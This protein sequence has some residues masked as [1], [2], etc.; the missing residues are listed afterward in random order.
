MTRLAIGIDIGGTGIKGGLVN[1]KSGALVGERI[2]V[3]TPEGGEPEDIA[4]VTREIIE[5]LNAPADTPIGVAFPSAIRGGITMLA[6]NVSKRWIGFEAEKFFE[7]ELGREIHFI[8]DA[9][10]A[11]F[12]EVKYGAARDHEGLVILTTLGTGIGSAFIYNG[13]LI[14]N[15]ELGHLEIDGF[16]AETKASAVARERDGIDYVEWAGRLQ[17]YYSHVEMLFSPDLFLVGGGVSKSH[18]QFL[19]LLTLRTPIIPATLFNRAGTLGAAALAYD[20][21]N[22]ITKSEKKKAKRLREAAEVS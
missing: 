15:T 22:A 6:A 1:L 16:D 3:L 21:H 9:D 4:A 11:G 19:P 13:V 17:R 10:A 2:R 18:D 14:P 8:N 20:A 12:A 7:S 5:Q